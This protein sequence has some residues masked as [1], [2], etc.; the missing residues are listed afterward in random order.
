MS[1]NIASIVDYTAQVAAG[2]Q[3]VALPNGE[4]VGIRSVY[5]AGQERYP[6]PLN[7]GQNIQ[8][9]P[10]NALEPFTHISD[11]PDAPTVAYLTQDGTVEFTWM[12]PMWL[13]VP[14]GDLATLRAVLLPFFDAYEA[15]FAP[16]PTL[17]GLAVL[18]YI[19]SF[20]KVE[21]ADD[22]ARLPIDLR[23]TEMVRY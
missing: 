15:A 1:S 6:D 18:S 13:Y 22:W 19:S 4:V 20:G 5:G 16:D 2:I 10:E 9:A 3:D 17:G 23:V 7:P 11:L 8:P 14:R 12:V 21:V